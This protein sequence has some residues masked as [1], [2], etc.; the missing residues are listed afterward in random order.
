[1]FDTIDE[2]D[3]DVLDAEFERLSLD[4]KNKMDELCKNPHDLNLRRT[5]MSTKEALMRIQTWSLLV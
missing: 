1:M 5:L 2:I 3:I 4:F